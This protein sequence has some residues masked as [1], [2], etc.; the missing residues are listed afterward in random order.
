[1]PKLKRKLTPA[2]RRARRERKRMIR[3]LSWHAM[4][5]AWAW[6][7]LAFAAA[8]GP[9]EMTCITPTKIVDGEQSETLEHW[10]RLFSDLCYVAPTPLQQET[11]QEAESIYQLLYGPP[12]AAPQAGDVERVAGAARRH[13]DRLAQEYPVA[14][15]RWDGRNLTTLTAPHTSLARGL[16][17]YLFVE[18][19]N[20]TTTS[21]HAFM[22]RD[23]DAAT[24]TSACSLPSQTT[25][26]WAVP[27][28]AS[29]SES[30]SIEFDLLESTAQSTLGRFAIPVSVVEPARIHGTLID[31]E[32]GRPRPGRV[33]VECSDRL[34]RHGE[35]YASNTTLSEKPVIFRPAMQKLPFFYSDGSFTINVPPG[36]TV[37]TVERG[38]ET[39]PVTQTLD[40]KPGEQRSV[41]FRFRRFLDLR[42][43]GWTSGDTHIHWVKNSWDQNEDL[44]LLSLVQ[45]AE[46]LRVA[47]NL[48]L[49]QWRAPEAG[50]PFVKPDHFPPG[51][52]HSHSDGEY[53][54]QMA[55]EYRNDNHYGHIN[56]LGIS[57][58]I[59]PLAT[60][61][62]SGGP[63]EAIDYPL[64]R[65][66]ILEARRQ[67]GISIEA[68]NL[69]PVFCSD[70]PVHVVLGLA[71]SLDQLDP[72][73][74]YRFLNSGFHVG[75]TN[76][77]DHPARVA[78]AVRA[79]VRT[80]GPFTYQ[81][82][83]DGVRHGRTFVTSGPL[84]MLT[85][86][87]VEIGDTL[88]AAKGTSLRI[89]AQ[90]RFAI[91]LGYFS[92]GQQRRS[93]EK[94]HHGP[95]RSANRIRTRR[96]R[97]P[98]VHHARLTFGTVRLPGRPRHRA[99]QCRLRRGRWSRGHPSRSGGI[100]DPECPAARRAN[101]HVGT[102]RQR[103][104]AARGTQACRG[105]A[106]QI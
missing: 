9:G 44:D 25:R 12:V 76:G 29:Q 71:D 64:N 30:T 2:E 58:L 1:M 82:W 106:G 68:H 38:F 16:V 102:V 96:R 55:E 85:V 48:T 103:R 20:A 50:G 21:L 61:P 86:N 26:T 47:N 75:L 84:V 67:D 39:M 60:G 13:Y 78:G 42:K 97:E 4:V 5:L 34:L 81:H 49:Y 43:L 19:D 7:L 104:T 28:V 65:T 33:R 90:R 88:Y 89:V 59:L 15:L 51:P 94:R 101:S 93:S 92:A 45:R 27:L 66:A 31:D 32:A 24:N 91:P 11:L 3:H 37:V 17:R 87:G 74:Y 52:V 62:G 98:L 54:V 35:A 53:H 56:L 41:E 22:Q 83:L 73:Y 80:E 57:E 63:P 46:D 18:I 69:G 6:T 40:L 10:Y 100:L 77:S 14:R 99:H 95:A 23:G 8:H 36:P 72:Q 79:Y 70:V 105:G